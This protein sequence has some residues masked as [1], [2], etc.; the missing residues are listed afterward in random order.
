MDELAAY[1]SKDDSPKT[2]LPTKDLR[3]R[4]NMRKDCRYGA[5][6][7]CSTDTA[8]ICTMEKSWQEDMDGADKTTDAIRGV[9][10][11]ANGFK[12]EDATSRDRTGSTN[13][14][15]LNHLPPEVEMGNIEYKASPLV[16]TYIQMFFTLHGA[17]RFSLY[18]SL[19]PLTA[20][21]ASV[22]R[23]MMLTC[24]RF[25]NNSLKK[26]KGDGRGVCSESGGRAR[27]R[28]H[29]EG[30]KRQGRILSKRRLKAGMEGA[31]AASGGSRLH[32]G[33]A[34]KEKKDFLRRV[35]FGWGEVKVL[36]P[37]LKQLEGVDQASSDAAI[38]QGE[39]V[40]SLEPVRVKEGPD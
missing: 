22:D 20:E 14:V 7:R 24:G 9:G 4:T 17:P 37:S 11:V 16:I 23:T 39:Q 18:A 35:P 21:S 36:G 30:E 8:G 1:F 3:C 27:L 2:I 40:Q 31:D 25:K 29:S 5:L 10:S 34:T 33:A 15:M 19:Y 6:R 12:P 32:N 28:G 26:T 13:L 38:F